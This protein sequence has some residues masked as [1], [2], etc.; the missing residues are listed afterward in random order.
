M[1]FLDKLG[2]AVLQAY[3]YALDARDAYKAKFK[4]NHKQL[5]RRS[6]LD[7]TNHSNKD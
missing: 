3:D 7:T 2:E 1:N 4:E 5:I 6:V